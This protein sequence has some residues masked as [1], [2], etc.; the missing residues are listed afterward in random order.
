[1][2]CEVI[3]VCLAAE[4]YLDGR[5]ENVSAESKQGVALCNASFDKKIRLVKMTCEQLHGCV[6]M[7]KGL[8]QTR[9]TRKPVKGWE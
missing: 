7:A 1:M 9:Y 4:S 2:T 6:C 8:Q 5:N 3:S